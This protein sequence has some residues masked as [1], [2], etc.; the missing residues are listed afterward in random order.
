[1]TKREIQKYFGVDTH[2][3][4]N[5]CIKTCLLLTGEINFMVF[6]LSF[7]ACVTGGLVEV[8]RASKR[9]KRRCREEPGLQL[10]RSFSRGLILRELNR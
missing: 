8:E 7:T 10:R 5:N 9:R 6:I 1:M 3:Q 2:E 4:G